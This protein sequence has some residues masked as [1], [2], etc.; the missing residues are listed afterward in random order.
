M[1]RGLSVPDTI[2][3]ITVP[4]IAVSGMFP[5]VP[6]YPYG[7]ASHPDVVIHQ[8]GSGNAKIEQR[9]LL[10]TGARRFSVR[11]TWM[12]DAQRIA[13]RNFWES[14]YGPYGAFGY[15]AP[16]DD[17]NGTTAL[18]CRFANEPLSW[19]MVADWVCSVGVTLVEIPAA[20]PAYTLNSTATRFPSG[21]LQAALLSQVQQL[22]PLIKIE[23][24]QAGYPAI[25]VS[26][27]RCT[28]GAQLYQARL[29]DFDGISQG[30]G[31]ES[32]DAAFTFGNADRVMRDLAND[33]DLYR[34]AIS[35]SL[36]H[37]GT[38][39]KVDLWKGDI[40]NWSC[41]AGPEFKVTASDGLYELNLPYP[42]RKI[43]RT[44][45]KA[46]DSQACPYASH[47]AMDLVHF[48][49]GDQTKCDKNYDTPNGCLAHGMKRY[50]GGIIAVP[51]GV[52]IKDNS[53]GVWGFGRSTLTSVSL[54]ADSIYDQVLPEVYTDTEMPVNCKVAAGRD[55][56]DFYEALG[57]VGEGPIVAYTPTHYEDK[58]GDGNA[59]TLVGHTLDGQAHHGFPK[60]D[61]GLRTC[62]GT[63]PAGAGDFFS[64][65]QSGNLT[66]GDFRK[67]YSGNSTLLDN[68]AAGTAFIVIR[69]SD[70]KGLQLS[71][72][73][74]HAMIATVAQGLSGWEWTSPGVR[75]Y[76]PCMVN[77]V[78]IAVNMVFRA[79]GLRLG[80]D[81]T[82][83]QLNAA[84]AY[85]DVQAAIDA[86]AICNDSV[87]KMVGA[88]TETQF[89]FR[90]T[91]QEE[92]PLRDWLQ[93]VLMN[94]LGYYTF[95]FGKLRIG[96]REN[97]SVVEAFTEGNILF[98]SLQLAPAKPSFNHLTA[99]FADQDFAFVNNSVAVYDIDHAVYVGGGA[100]PMYLKSSVNLCGTSTKS[101]AARIVSTRLREE[102]GG[103]NAAEWKAARQ[104]GFKTT[105]LALNTEPGMV[106]SMTQADMPGGAGEFRV[107]SW[108]LNKDFSID[109]QGR[110][111]TDSM[112]DLVAGPKPADVEPTPV[113]EEILYDTGVPGIVNG[114]PK[115]GDYG[116]IALDDITVAPDD[117]GNE[118]LVSAHEVAMGLYYVDELAVDLW[119]S[120]DADLDRD[121]DPATVAC[122]VN[123]D[124]SR[125][126]KVGDFVVFN[127]ETKN[128]DVG[129][130][131]SYESAQIVGPGNTG[132]VVP[133]GNFQLQRAYPGVDPGFATFGT[134][135]CAHKAGIRFYRLDLKQFT[136]SVKKGFFRTPGITPRIEA[137][138]PS[139]CVVAMLV[140]VANNF[141]YSPFTVFPL[142]HQSEPFA[143][144]M[145]TCN[146]GAY[147]FQVPGPLAVADTVVIPMRVHDT[148]SIRCI[149]AYVQTPT[150]DGQSAYLV[151]VS[152]D[153][154]ATWEPLEYMGIAQKLPGGYKNTYDFL[155]DG[156]YGKPATRRL[157]YDDCGIVLTQNVTGGGG[158]QTVSIASYGANVLGL[159][160]GEFVH[161]NLGQA[162]EEYVEV[163]TVDP[164]AQL[165]TAN[166]TQDHSTG[167]TVRPTIWPTPV[168]NEGDTLAFDILAV[169]SPDPGSDVT[170]VIQ[171]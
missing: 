46:F 7:R 136:Y 88:G 166:F 85:F 160:V 171:T 163:L 95:S 4:E 44:C 80:A 54:V 98:R 102:L 170:V 43:S 55:E 121:T 79:R 101:Q 59:E 92:K 5:I 20:T 157:P 146:G 86:A 26:D 149:Y 6:E 9:F 162:D 29:I 142:S 58:D 77:P 73:G 158:A 50:Y 115:L 76:G 109:V 42:T 62:L 72:P 19:E 10:G 16:N 31:N 30:M 87:T 114:T 15:N 82:T 122:T 128:P 164:A 140:G 130:L 105:A 117:S 33:V 93:E 49:D 132:D 134:L 27:R 41:D 127:D 70:A 2:G 106:C 3:N 156:G 21:G 24:L 165:F 90:G 139:A 113:P 168:L 159:D 116:T 89:A 119:A 167:A 63:D 108:R 57:I 74:D 161:I 37:V 123:P 61:L 23:P 94:C 110:T 152:R 103:T 12:N 118:N 25:Y 32:D 65:D 34:A 126:F 11:R 56:S 169:A 1:P 48:P 78:W 67:V 131:R 143:P 66:G 107:A 52:R 36:F 97:S 141:G 51:Q 17:G 135:R 68:F 22:I 91:L 8:F 83:P 35:F 129:Y 14:K 40:V 28:V 96:I 84:E 38:G 124:T 120:L 60:N 71:S 155:V 150:T 13:L 47:G 154:S 148:A 112:Y 144:G 153:D 64:L 75:V 39:I 81:A 125:T 69:R 145:R 99:N 147:T 100:G 45:W 133:T 111:T 53:T 137:I 151:K 138:L 104:I 18:T